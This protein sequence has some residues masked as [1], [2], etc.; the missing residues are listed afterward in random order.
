MATRR[1]ALAVVARAAHEHDQEIAMKTSTGRA[2]SGEGKATPR[3]WIGLAVIALPCILYAMDLTILNLA[4][5]AVSADLRPT[6]AQLLW[7]VDVYGFLAAGSL[8]TM[9]TLGDR[10][11][12]RKLL[13]IGSASF[14]LLS[15]VAAFA[16]SA[17]VLI[18]A[19]ALL[20]VA[21]AT[22]APST[23]SLISNM[24]RDDRERTFAVSVWIASFSLGGAIGPVVGGLILAHFWWGAVFLAPIPV[25]GLL[26][27]AGPT[28]LPEHKNPNAGRLD[29]LSAFL[30]LA[31]VLPVIYGV[32]L[33]AEGG[34]LPQAASAII[35]GSVFGALFVRRQTKLLDPLLDLRLFRRPALTA[36]L[37]IYTLDFFVGFGI[38]VLIAQYLQL[39]LG[40][41]PLQAGLWSTPAGLGFV[42]GSL[43]TS[44]ALRLMRPAYVL[45]LGWS[46]GGGGLAVMAYA[47]NVHNLTLVVLGNVLFSIGTAPGIAIIAD[48]VVSSAPREQSGAASALSETASEFG[49]ALGIALLG[50]LATFLYRSALG[51][52]LPSGTPVDAAQTALRGIGA[53]A[54]LPQNLEGAAALLSAARA[55]YTGAVDITLSTAAGLAALTAVVAVAMF[56]DHKKHRQLNV[57]PAQD[58]DKP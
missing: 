30:S 57:T 25:M 9:G 12:R 23:L 22:M 38:L 56:R 5:P 27:M 43:L 46:L 45:G 26:L 47:V 34:D 2:A 41:T 28:L 55:A 21:G 49:G 17:E 8:L 35:L 50:S 10:I 24:F 51:G 19:R 29:V 11:G 36:A 31:T 37:A 15:L 18:V 53:A 42:V 32:K 44:A 54:S 39:V 13:L 58:S 14:G 7:I 6:A 20:G 48:L 3:E 16:R 33:A 1:R 4:V 40:L 52:I